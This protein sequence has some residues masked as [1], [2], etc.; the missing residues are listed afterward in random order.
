M[1][2]AKRAVSALLG[3]CL[4]LC[5]PA[6]VRAKTKDYGK[7]AYDCTRWDDIKEDFL[8]AKTDRLI[9]VKCQ[10]GTNA[11][12]E[13]WE[14][15]PGDSAQNP[16]GE[17]APQWKQIVS[18]KAFTGRNGLGKKREG[19]KKTPVG[20]Y[21]IT[22][23]FG[24]KK[25]PGTAGISYTKLNNYHY[26]SSEKATY[27]RFIDVRTLNRTSMSGE[28]L[29]RYDPEYNYALAIGYNR[30][31]T[32]LKGSGIFLHCTGKNSYTAG[33]VAVPEKQMKKIIQHTT[34]HTKICI[35]PYG[36][37]K[38]HRSQL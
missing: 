7:T 13:M 9:F 12:V 34:E 11:V 23:A 5:S 26:W 14:K 21:R 10:E 3:C 38:L 35:Y 37:E 20:I 15:I 1:K 28:H 33:C 32:Y 25:S 8:D 29:I 22:M 18:C 36:F 30:K 4:L 2:Q 16:S 31:C 24:R 19:D 17:G 27:N 6:L